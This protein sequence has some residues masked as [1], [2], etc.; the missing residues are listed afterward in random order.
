MKRKRTKLT[1][2]NEEE[3]EQICDDIGW[4]DNTT[5]TY[6]TLADRFN[7]PYQEVQQ[8][9][10]EHFELILSQMALYGYKDNM[11][12]DEIAH[13]LRIHKRNVH[14]QLGDF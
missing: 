11:P 14:H 6:Q 10:K 8:R 5:E 13:E 4:G 7:M 12:Q 3:F 1:T 2:E 9:F